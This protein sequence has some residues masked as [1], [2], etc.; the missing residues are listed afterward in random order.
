MLVGS[1][2]TLNEVSPPVYGFLGL[3]RFSLPTLLIATTL[4]AVMLGLVALASPGTN[5]RAG[6]AA[7][8]GLVASV[9]A[10]GVSRLGLSVNRWC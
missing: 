9:I 2:L 4:V 5:R 3:E 6:S 1:V 8:D 10:P 7:A